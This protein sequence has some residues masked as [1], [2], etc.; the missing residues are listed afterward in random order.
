MVRVRVYGSLIELECMVTALVNYS[1][2]LSLAFLFRG[3]PDKDMESLL[4]SRG[5]GS[6]SQ[7]EPY[8]TQQR[9]KERE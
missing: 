3:N 5:V 2:T 6:I 7:Y 4:S 8:S 1:L 9:E